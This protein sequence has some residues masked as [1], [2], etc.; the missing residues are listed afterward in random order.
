MGREGPGL[1]LSSIGSEP[2]EHDQDAA[3]QAKAEAKDAA[4]MSCNDPS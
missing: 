1:G 4:R 2:H 3:G